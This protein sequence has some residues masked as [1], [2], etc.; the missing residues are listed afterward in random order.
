MCGYLSGRAL[1]TAAPRAV[2]VALLSIGEFLAPLHPEPSAEP[3]P[4]GLG[5]WVVVDEEMLENQSLILSG[6]LTVEAGGSLTLVNSTLL[7]LCREPAERQVRVKEGGTLNIINSTVASFDTINNPWFFV[8]PNATALFENSTFNGI[9]ELWAPPGEPTYE[10]DPINTGN[11]GVCIKTDYAA[12]HN[13][14][15]SGADYGLVLLRASPEVRGCT[16][17]GNSAGLVLNRAH[18]EISD[19]VFHRNFYGALL[20]GASPV[21]RRC[22]FTGNGQG[23]MLDGSDPVVRECVFENQSGNGIL[24]S[25]WMGIAWTLGESNPDVAN[26]RFVRNLYGITSVEEDDSDIPHHSLSVENCEFIANRKGGLNWSERCL[27]PPPTRL[28]SWRVTGT[29]LIQDEPSFNFNGSVSVEHGGSLLI[30]RSIFRVNGGYDG[31]CWIM[32]S[33]GGSLELR[34]S[35]L[36]AH[37]ASHAYALRCEPG[38]ALSMTSSL[39]RDCGWSTASPQTSGPFLESPNVYI[40]GS[41]IDYNPVGLVFKEVQDAIIE[42]SSI[43]GL[44]HDL[45]LSSSSVRILNSSLRSAGQVVSV[46]DG[47]S[48]L[49][50]LNT[51]L[52]RDRFLFSDGSSALS[53]SWYLNARA[54]WQDGSPVPGAELLVKDNEGVEALR[55]TSAED[56][57]VWGGVLREALVNRSTTRIF[58]PHSVSFSHGPV[59]NETEL[60][61]NRSLSVQL[62]LTDRV[63]P[64][65][66]I[67]SPPPAA[68]LSMAEVPVNGTAGDNIGVRRVEL[69]VDGYRRYVVFEAVGEGPPSMDWGLTL[70]LAEGVHTIQALACDASGNSASAVVNFL[71]DTTPPMVKI[72]SPQSGHLTNQSLLSVWGFCEPGSRVFVDG[73]EAQ[74]DRNIFSVS[75]LLS[76]GENLVTAVAMDGSGNSNSSSVTV[77]LDTSPPLLE[78]QSPEEGLVTNVPVARVSGR[79]EEDAEVLINGRRV[80]LVGEPGTFS[81]SIA[82]VDGENIITIDAVDPAGNHRTVTRKV[83]LDAQPPYVEVRHPPDGFLTNQPI[84]TVTGFSE[85]GARL[86][87]GAKE[88]FVP[89]REDQRMDFS[90]PL[91]LAEGENT[92]V[93]RTVD[94]AGNSNTTVRRV[95]LDTIPP[96]ISIDSPADRSCTTRASIY[97]MGRTEPRVR[98]LVSGQ[99]TPVGA[100]GSFTQEVTLGTGINKITVRAV[101]PA[102]NVNEISIIVERRPKGG[103]EELITAPVPDWPFITFILASVSIMVLEGYVLY[104]SRRPKN[105]GGGRGG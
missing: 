73:K 41:T 95:V 50:A 80:A 39:L 57:W 21:I 30:N 37:N 13:C 74:V 17:T 34:S 8:E 28:S 71:V 77:V 62:V 49:D 7:I 67:I 90:I 22:S 98:L 70:E 9:G 24:C 35:E 78:L 82:L 48:L 55:G 38:S 92:L 53:V 63:P 33:R 26:C 51:T 99:E 31:E 69:N 25:F 1:I 89:G 16:F 65:V 4:F 94:A 18:P 19:C 102:G 14:T 68:S 100:S 27:R 83:R 84:L 96:G 47:A 43:R 105:E 40:I 60:T 85:G 6:D 91:T 11:G 75:V 3:P 76:E 66:R 54:I 86:L 46:L 104:R 32:V 29:A 101:D 58:T 64:T 59:S 23:M 87:L 20:H 42:S 103:G 93:I 81:T 10:L 61:V 72:A 15:F 36:R 44:E 52:D 97:V 88:T 56:G 5:D 79:M 12:V 2:L 45:S